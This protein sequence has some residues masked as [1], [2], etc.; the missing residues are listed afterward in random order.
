MIKIGAH[1]STAGG[2][3]T[4]IERIQSLGGNCLQIFGASP[5]QW[6]VK[7]PSE[8]DIFAFKQAVQESGV[9]PIY[10]HAAYLPNLASPDAEVRKKSIK[11][12][13]DHLQIA[14]LIGAN[15]LIFHIGSGKESPKETAMKWV[16]SGCKEILRSV[17]GTTELIM[18]NSAGGGQKLGSF[19]QEIGEMI[20]MIN[21]S[22]MKVCWDT[23][24]ALEA[25]AIE[26]YSPES[27]KKL[28]NDCDKAFG[29]DKLVAIHANDS[30]TPFN[31]H[32]DRHENIGQG[33]IGMEG[34]K[35]LAKEKR[36]RDKA[37]I[38]EVPGFD[39]L[40]PD[41]KNVDLLNSSF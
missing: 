35:N 15:G 28:L 19:P 38:L 1:V 9:G 32:H 20:K 39:G 41:Q 18:E 16:V 24:H 36:L 21:S 29:L 7:M 8:A 30:K 25:G 23:A 6:H 37:W 40:G 14:D 13:S 22:R 3:H 17:S 10:L 31:S 27:I 11:N 34:F 33:H 2:L 4:A 26:K 5:R 12:L